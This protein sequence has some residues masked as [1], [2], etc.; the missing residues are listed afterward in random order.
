MPTAPISYGEEKQKLFSKYKKVPWLVRKAS[1]TRLPSASTFVHLRSVAAGDPMRKAFAGFG[2]PFFNPQQLA[3][4]Q[5]E[6]EAQ[7]IVIASQPGLFNV[8][9]IRVSDEGI[10]DS[11]K[12][13]ASY[14]HPL[15]WAPIIM[16]GESGHRTN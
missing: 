12:I 13:V 16:V 14:A 8:R 1:V 5:K 9:G 11:D 6:K 10:L 3:E 7:T 2:D 15:F 4:A